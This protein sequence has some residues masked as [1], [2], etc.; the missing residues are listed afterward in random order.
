[1]SISTPVIALV[2]GIAFIIILLM[3]WKNQRDKAKF[4]RDFERS[5]LKPEKHDED[6]ETSQ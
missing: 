4:E 1:M 3:V 6:K 2:V 5:E